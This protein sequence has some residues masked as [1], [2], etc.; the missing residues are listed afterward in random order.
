MAEKKC[1]YCGAKMI[2]YDHSDM[3]GKTTKRYVCARWGVCKTER[4]MK[5]LARRRAA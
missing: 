3:K 1:P 5:E 4:K 2:P